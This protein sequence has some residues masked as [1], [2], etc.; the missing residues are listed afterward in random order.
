M[1][2]LPMTFRTCLL[3]VLLAGCACACL[4]DPQPQELTGEPAP[5]SRWPALV[6][7]QYT[8]VDQ[9]QSEL[10]SP[11]QGKLSLLPQGDHQD[12]HTIGFYGGWAPLTWL[13]LYLDTE[14][15]MGAGVS[16][17]TG[18]GSLTNGDVIRE[19]AAGLKKAF[20]IARSY[21]RL[22]LPLGPQLVRLERA[23][24]QIAGTEAARRLELKAGRLA[25]SDDLDKNRYANATRTQFMNAA[26]W[27]NT[28][29]DYAAN[30]V[31]FSDGFIL[32]YISPSWALRYALF[33][34]PT[35]ANGQT[36]ETLNLAR[37]ENLELT[38]SPVEDSTVVRLLVFRNTAR[39]GDYREAIAAAAG[40][41]LPPVVSD[42]GHD[43]RHKYG[44]GVNLEQPLADAG[45]TGLF[46]RLGWNDAATED[47]AFTEEDRV[48]SFGGQLSG[49]HWRRADDRL[50]VG[51][52]SAGLSAAHRDYLAAGG[53]GFMLGDGTLNY[54]HEQLL[55]AYY[56]A[57]WSW[58]P[59]STPIRLQL[60]PDFQY[61]QNP[62]MNRDR[63]PVRFWSVRLH[64]EY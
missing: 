25:I 3:A 18:V 24:D 54:G 34:M 62:G 42:T 45:D 56:R 57:Q 16:N 64:L 30:T 49:L 59:F 19:G 35:H 52:S 10:T 17:G 53:S 29:W 55:E 41:G 32:S 27:Q 2:K 15:F 60:S 12:S 33:K 20:Y 31:G 63:G 1:R 39:M 50:G 40:T 23:Q 48:V 9:Q 36:L 4:A 7:A 28:A 37:G 61:V 13:Q 51:V 46:V 8:F 58:A 22:M 26:L 38:L 43:G 6:G 47:F 11:Y 14:K 21:V 5:D 44:F